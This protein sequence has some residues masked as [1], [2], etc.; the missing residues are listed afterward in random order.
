LRKTTADID[1]RQCRGNQTSEWFVEKHRAVQDLET[2]VAR[3]QK[4]IEAL[5]VG[6][7]KVSGQLELNKRASETGSNNY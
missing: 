4:Q 3:Q 1:F 2:A 5:T 7:Q 6:L